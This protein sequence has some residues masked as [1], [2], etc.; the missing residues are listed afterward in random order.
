MQ[1]ILETIVE[2]NRAVAEEGIV[3]DYI[4]A[5]NQVDPKLLGLAVQT[6]D[7][8]YTVGDTDVPFTMQ[9]ISKVLALML[10]LIDHGEDLFHVVDMR[11]SSDPF[12]S[13]YRLDFQ[14]VTKPANPMMNSGAIAITSQIVGDRIQRLLSLMEEITGHKNMRYNEEVYKSESET[15]DKNRAIAYLMKSRHIIHGDIEKQLDDYFKQCSIEVTATDLAKIGYFLA[16]GC[17]GLASYGKMDRKRLS[18]ILLAIMTTA[19]MYDH[20]GEYATRV[21]VPT[22]SGVGGG[23]MGAVPGRMGIGIY[24]P[25]LDVV[26]NSIAG[27]HIMNDLAEEF[28]LSIFG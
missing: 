2:E 8:L 21:G 26:G 24:S 20:S 14:D 28:D 6:K 23:I 22:K 19:G 10:A 13:L 7:Q 15:G 9:S 18:R 16:N 17:H 4:P 25:P 3:A 11:Q 5:L 1:K 27:I 12:N